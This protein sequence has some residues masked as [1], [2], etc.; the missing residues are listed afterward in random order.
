[1][2]Y[3]ISKYAKN[4]A[5]YP[6]NIKKRSIIDQRLHFESGVVFVHRGFIWGNKSSIND[7]DREGVTEAYALL[8]VFLETKQWAT[9][10]F[11]SIADYSLISSISSLD[12]IIP[13]DAQKYPRVVTWMKKFI[14][15]CYTV[16]TL[17]LTMA[18]T[19]YMFH[20][21][22]PAR[23]VLITAKAIGLDLVHK[24]ID[25]FNGEHLSPEFLKLNP[26]H[27]IPT[28]VD[29][30]GFTVW[31][32]HAIIIYLVSK[33]AR[34]DSLYPKDIKKRAI[35][36][37]RLHFES[38]V[39]FTQ[40]RALARAIVSG[41]KTIINDDDKEAVNEIFAFLEAFLDGKQ[42]VA[43]DSVSIADYSLISSIGSIGV[44]VPIDA[45]KY[46]K[47]AAWIK[48]VE[49][50]PEYEANKKGLK[51]F[52]NPQHTVPTLVDDDGFTI[53]D[54]HAIMVYLVS[55]Y[56]K[57]DALYPKDI[58]KRAIINQRLH[59]ESGVVFVQM[60]AI[61]RG[62]HDGT[63][64]NVTDADK[65][66][67]NEVYAFLETFLSGNKWVA[68][69]SVSV[70]DYSLISSISCLNI[71]VPIDAEKYP[72]VVDWMKNVQGLPEFE[73]NP[74][75]TVPT[76]VDDDG[77]T[78]WDSHAI[79]VYLISKYAKNDALYPKDIK[80]R[81]IVDQRLHFESGLPVFAGKKTA[82]DA[83]DK[84]ILEEA[85]AFLEAFLAGNRWM[86]GDYVSIADYSII[87]SIS[88]LN[89]FV[90]VDAE[91]FPKLTNWM[92]QCRRLI[93]MAPTLYMMY[94]SPPV[95]AVLIT[96]KAI[97]LDLTIKEVNFLTGDHL[98][99]EYLKLNPQHTVPTLVDDDGFTIWDSHAIMVYL[100]SKYAKN[101]ALY[102]KDIKKRAIIDQRL[103]FEAG[104]VFALLRAIVKPILREGKTTI[105]DKGKDA[106][107][108]A[109]AFLES[110]LEG[111]QWAAGDSVSIADY[112]L[113]S[114]V[115]SINTIIP[116][117]V[118]KY[119]KV[120]AWMKKVE[121]LPEYEANKKGLAIF[122]EMLKSKLTKM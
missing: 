23:A 30:D 80:K 7:A 91:K 72:K 88:S 61:S 83:A 84:E 78:I 93:T 17:F 19:L 57:N 69:D 36:D 110:F 41:K 8:E 2:P 15:R 79:M 100:I 43:G 62:F 49:E 116:I 97:G 13:V 53:W 67:A 106:V 89:V 11:V 111:R 82:V 96:A 47:I 16:H 122:T 119:P 81:A 24:E 107:Y 22:P 42:W 108:E 46:P 71:V 68:G 34:N 12:K 54:S 5:L 115:S 75:H 44:F 33:Y 114:S 92:K 112:S 56:G 37:Q 120:V 27:T 50:L 31:D 63:K 29:D 35:I 45:R 87:S 94:P 38:G 3:L 28:L 10:D 21:S 9:V 86:A 51:L 99:P 40:L 4:H 66:S 95:R 48:K 101:D 14:F 58:R 20:E 117:D 90:P 55:R 52:L 6:K 105:D 113:I 98:K 76:L 103:Y 32:S 26:Q 1:M 65:E 102:P 59:F 64:N 70:A 60:R 121:G 74:Q 73:L 25:F 18:P 118:K 104:V 109:Y 39:V 77:F 85:Y